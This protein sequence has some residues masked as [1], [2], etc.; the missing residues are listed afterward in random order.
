MLNL[1]KDF[2]IDTTPSEIEELDLAFV[3][4]VVPDFPTS[5][6]TYIQ[7]FT[8]TVGILQHGI[9]TVPNYHHGYCLDDNARALLVA[10]MD[11]HVRPSTQ[12]HRLIQTYLA[13]IQYMQKENGQFRN[14][15]SFSHQFLDEIGTEDSY[16]RTLWALGTFIKLHRGNS[17]TSLAAEMLH[18]AIPYSEFLRSN[19]AIAYTLIGLIDYCKAIDYIDSDI[20]IYIRNLANFLKKEYQECHKENWEWYENIVSYDN[21]IIPL[22]LLRAANLLNHQEMQKIALQ[23]A[24]FL[25]RVT[26]EQGH[27]SP[28]G[29]EGWYTYQGHRS[30]FGQQPIEVPS[31]IL[32]YKQLYAQTQDPLYLQRAADTFQW[33]FGKNDLGIP[34]YDPQSKGCSDGL[35]SHGANENQGAESAIS[36]WQAYFYIG[37]DLD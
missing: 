4:S 35:D 7:S 14:F 18:K 22:S 9:Y 17:F 23:S 11:Y 29:N 33:F 24:G 16:G 32:L 26:F 1:V 25:D 34:L 31:T 19:R 15:L 5:D 2:P 13:Y 37:H 20:I 10:G 21:A 6:L 36:F 12:T 3:K 8:N 30:T 28:I 27:F